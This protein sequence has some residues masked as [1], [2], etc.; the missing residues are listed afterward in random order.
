VFARTSWGIALVAA[1]G[2]A[3]RAVG[4]GAPSPDLRVLSLRSLQ[5]GRTVR[6]S[7]RDLGTLTGSVVGVRDGALWLGGPSAERRVPVAGIDSV[8]VSRGHAGTGALVGG[9]IG[10]VV[11]VAAMSGRSC[12]LGDN[13]CITGASLAATGIMASGMLLGAVIGGEAKS[14]DLRY[15]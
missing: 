14:W 2:L 5:A 7:G 8:W 13:N 9:L 11:A 4:Q 3:G 12:Q 6:V 10:V 15:P 1:V